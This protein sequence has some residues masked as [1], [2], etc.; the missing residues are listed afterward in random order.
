[1]RPTAL[2][3]YLERVRTRT[4]R[5]SPREEK[6]LARRVRAGGDLAAA[7]TLANAHLT[8]VVKIARDFRHLHP[9]LLELI[10]EGNLALIRAI[11]RYDPN[12]PVT[13]AA[14]V[15]SWVRTYIARFILANLA[16]DQ[17]FFQGFA[18]EE[19]ETMPAARELQ[20]TLHSSL[21]SWETDLDESSD[22][23]GFDPGAVEPGEA[24]ALN[25][26]RFSVGD[27]VAPGPDTLVEEQEDRARLAAVLPSFERQL[28][29]RERE[30]FRARLI[31]DEPPTLSQKGSELGL[32][33]ERIRQIERELTERLR[34]RL[35]SDAAI[36][37]RA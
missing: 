1:M 31:A 17:V 10:Q 30:I 4:R 15:A 12:R 26:A 9:N 37:R 6:R 18:V 14:Y 24:A 2:A 7:R 36:S 35:T 8:L 27:D 23:E 32:S 5:L 3:S 21:R 25:L 16:S 20:H 22:D 34:A 11:Q 19:D 33:A 28:T 13:V 29:P